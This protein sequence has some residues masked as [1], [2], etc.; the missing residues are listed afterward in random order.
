MGPVVSG[1]VAFVTGASRG[2]GA[3]TA[4]ALAAQGHRVAVGY[5]GS[6]DAAAKVAADIGGIPVRIDVTDAASIDAAFAHVEETL[7]KV[8]VLVN[9]AGVTGDG[10]AMRMTDDQW[11]RVLSTNLDG[12]F[13]VARRALPAMVKARFGRIV[14]VGSVA[15]LAGSGGQ[16]NYA[17][18]KAGLVGLARSLAREVGSRGITTNVVA[19]GPI[20][21]DMTAV[22]P[23]ERKA[24][25]CAQVPLGRMGT[26][27]EVASVI[28]FLCTDAAAYVNGAVVPVD[29]GL[30]M[31]H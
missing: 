14:L 2:I 23:E 24:D 9:S 29:G 21:T 3:G 26:V 13:T 15:G 7:G 12:P 11:R 5:S 17:A 8:E 19:P 22:L 20:D 6:E 4:A 28:A 25:L 1:R 16:V 31:G 18:A 10:L 27:A 30:G